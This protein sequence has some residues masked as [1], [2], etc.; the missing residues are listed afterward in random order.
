MSL[1]LGI[2]V[3]IAGKGE[4]VKVKSLVDEYDFL[5]DSLVIKFFLSC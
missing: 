4:V 3:G 1:G 2:L 5:L